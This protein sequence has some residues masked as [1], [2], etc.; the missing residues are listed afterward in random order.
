MKN[1][2]GRGSASPAV[3]AAVLGLLVF[4]SYLLTLAPGLMYTDSGELAAACATFGV[5]HPTGYPLFTILGHV[6]TLLP[7]PSVVWGLN[8]LAAL[9]M[10]AAVA[11]IYRVT[12]ALI[13]RTTGPTAAVPSAAAAALCFGWSA[14]AWSQATSIEVYSLHALLT[15]STLFATVRSTE[16]SERASRWTVASGLLFGLMMANHLSSAFLAPGLFI[17]WTATGEPLRERLRRW[18]YLI[19]PSLLGLGLYAVLP[20][21]SAADPPINWGMVHRGLDAFL[22]HVKGTQFG[23]WMFS[24][25]AAVKA[26][27]TIFWRALTDMTLWIGL[28]LVVAGIVRTLSVARRLALGIVVIVVGNL[29]I[30]LGYAIPDIDPYFL[31]TLM[32]VA[33]LMGVGIAARAQRHPSPL[34]WGALAVPAAVMITNLPEQDRSNHTT[35]RDYTTWILANAEPNAIILT[36]QW[37]YFCSAAIYLQTV[38]GVRPDVAL[39]DKELLRRT[40]YAP[41]LTYRYPEVMAPA[42]EA[43]D[44]YMPYLELFESNA[45]A[46]NRRTADVRAI[47]TRFVAM[48][49]AIVANNPT[50]PVYVTPELL[51]EEEGFAAG[52]QRL[53]AGPLVR[54]VRDTSGYRQRESTDG[55]TSLVA[56][57]RDRTERLDVGLRQ[58]VM[59]ELATMAVYRLDAFSDTAGFRR[60]RDLVRS[61]DPRDGITLQL[62]RMLP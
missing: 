35:V 18:P 58:T 60:Y 37:D 62:E 30:S 33:I 10:S 15:A 53:P 45:D 55:L 12:H 20:L 19:L 57:L 39:I 38:E 23:V 7:F 5:A 41:Y 3:Q 34:W 1:I 13:L 47:Q 26:N 28:I 61:C 31:P 46:F 21:R 54:L 29:G 52:W 17:L 2:I 49:N 16:S 8:V 48:L 6:W 59:S 40:W 42:R 24:D 9:W 44:A 51:N 50:R 14:T 11:M 27:G 22:Y 56:G 36:R 4:V 43:V 32:A 25:D